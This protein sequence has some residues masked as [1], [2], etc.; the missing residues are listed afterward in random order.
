MYKLFLTIRYVFKPL[1][2]V[3]VLALAMS[4]VIFT[5]APSVMNG[6]QEDFHARIRGTMSDMVLKSDQPLVVPL[7]PELQETL[8]KVPG[9][10]A[11]APFIEHPA[12]DREFDKIDYCLIRGVIPKE[13]EK[14][15]EFKQF[16]LSDRDWFLEERD[17]DIA[18]GALKERIAKDSLGYAP[19]PKKAQAELDAAEAALAA[20]KARG[21]GPE[22]LAKLEE[23]AGQARL[24]K[25]QADTQ[26]ERIYD[27]LENGVEDPLDPSKKIPAVLAGVFLMKVYDIRPGSILKLTTAA[28]ENR[29]VQQDK[30]FLVVG[31]FRA[32]SHETDRR[33]LY[34]GLKASQQF[35]GTDKIT[36]YSIKLKNYDEARTI[37]QSCRDALQ[38]LL[39]HMKLDIHGSGLWIK[40]WEQQ[41]ENLLRA[42]GMERL[43]IK[44]ITGM[45]VLAASSSIFL[46]LFM[47]VQNKVRELGILRA[48]GG[49]N[50]GSLQIFLGQG[51]LLG[52][53]G[54]ILGSA[55]GLL[56]A[57]YINEI[58]NFI[59]A[60]TGWHPFPP[61]VYYLEKIPSKIYWSEL[62][63]NAAITMALG[64]FFAFVPAVIAAFR[65]PIRAIRHD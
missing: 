49:S 26:I 38:G 12:L 40:T 36:G 24:F 2:L 14:V 5:A 63:I 58:A 45:I 52:V 47:T 16:I 42:V 15:S 21:A 43:L 34:M 37:R 35:I 25:K 54:M 13:E 64:L 59:H 60:L 46:V 62:A 27:M 28:G 17:F 8:E 51:F 7:S 61:E 29:E 48:V 23:D 6:F 50:W 11:V 9:V 30:H 20:A 55:L 31:A 18:K 3:T 22:E 41:N 39:D 10:Q 56:G 19:G 57:H 32:G 4:V 44:L 53:I 65:P 1:S 33:V